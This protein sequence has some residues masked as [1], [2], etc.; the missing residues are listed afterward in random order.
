MAAQWP[1]SAPDQTGSAER[2]QYLMEICFWD[3]LSDSDLFTVDRTLASSQGEL[4][5]R[6]DSVV[7]AT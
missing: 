5:E 3:F 7:R 4:K 1:T 6:P 2:A